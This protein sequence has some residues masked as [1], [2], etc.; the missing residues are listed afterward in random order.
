[1]T[2]PSPSAGAP[3][4]TATATAIT[5]AVSTRMHDEAWESRDIY[6]AFL[7][8]SLLS[9][10]SAAISPEERARSEWNQWWNADGSRYV[11]CAPT[12]YVHNCPWNDWTPPSEARRRAAAAKAAH[13]SP[14]LA[15]IRVHVCRSS[16]S[17]QRGEQMVVAFASVD[18][19]T[20][21]ARTLVLRRGCETLAALP[22]GRFT[23]HEGARVVRLSL[24][25]S[26]AAPVF[27]YIESA[28]RRDALL[29]LLA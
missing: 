5:E 21:G 4:P 22:L 12:D 13:P 29:A 16:E 27:L 26:S 2:T 23:V 24:K 14:G 8:A 3:R 7:Q 18:E 25:G 9:Y 15:R 10:K 20:D 11:A 19:D 1:M 6:V 28:P 17:H